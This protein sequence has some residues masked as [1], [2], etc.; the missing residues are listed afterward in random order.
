[1]ENGDDKQRIKYAEIYKTN[2]KK[3]REDIRKYNQ[4]ILRETIMA[5]KTLTK[6]RRT[7]KL[8]Q[9]RLINLLDKKGRDIHDQ[10]KIIQSRKVLHR[11]LEIP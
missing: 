6:V 1:M 5:S 3:A 7:Q 4:D 9:D 10:D 11:M 2:T 8:G